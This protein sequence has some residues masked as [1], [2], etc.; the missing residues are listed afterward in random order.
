MSELYTV[1]SREQVLMYLNTTYKPKEVP[2]SDVLE[3]NTWAWNNELGF[4]YNK[5]VGMNGNL[6]FGTWVLSA[7]DRVNMSMEVY[8]KRGKVPQLTFNEPGVININRTGE[9]YTP[10]S[11]F[12]LIELSSYNTGDGPRSCTAGL[13]STL[14]GEGYIRNVRIEIIRRK[15]PL[16]IIT[17]ACSIRTGSTASS[18]EEWKSSSDNI[19]NIQVDE[20]NDEIKLTYKK[21]VNLD[22]YLRPVI[23]T[24][25]A[26]D[27]NGFYWKVSGNIGDSII[28]KPYRRSDDVP[29]KITSINPFT[30]FSFVATFNPKDLNV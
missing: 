15:R 28:F 25:I 14:G 23:T 11:G 8:V 18:F 12:T 4:H 2:E 30:N 3:M 19:A 1:N 22:Y 5:D 16:P 7:G 26:K 6:N 24:G 27:D 17:Y 10:Q 9:N 21:P 29:A 20:T 13:V